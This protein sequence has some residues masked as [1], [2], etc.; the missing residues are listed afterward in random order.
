MLRVRLL[1]ACL[2]LCA[3]TSSPRLIEVQVDN[4]LGDT[5]V[6]LTAYEIFNGFPLVSMWTTSI[7]DAPP[8]R[9]VR[10]MEACLPV[11]FAGVEL[12]VENADVRDA[13]GALHYAIE[14]RQKPEGGALREPKQKDAPGVAYFS[15]ALSES[16]KARAATDVAEFAAG[17]AEAGSRKK[18][19]CWGTN[20]FSAMDRAKKR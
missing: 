1:S 11:H 19:G 13:R 12:T 14:L 3:C 6:T 10:T 16:G 7:W 4:Q 20:I 17:V 5:P 15:G 8:G 18:L 9:S 2:C